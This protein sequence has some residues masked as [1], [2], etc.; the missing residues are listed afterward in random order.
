[1]GDQD[2]ARLGVPRHLHEQVAEALDIGVVQRRVDLV[3]HA[4][5]RG[6]GQEH[7]KDQA[8]GR[9]CLFPAR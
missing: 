7:R 1:M 4:D 5:R 9:Q 6:I 3:E 2:E 8:H